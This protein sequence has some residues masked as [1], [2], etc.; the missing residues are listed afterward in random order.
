MQKPSYKDLEKQNKTLKDNI[1]GL[2]ESKN[3]FY[4]LIDN[5]P[6]MFKIIELIYDE[7]G[8][9]I[10]YYFREINTKFML[11]TNLSKGQLINKR[12]REVIGEIPEEWLIC[13]SKIL[14]TNISVS[15]IILNSPENIKYE[16]S[17]WK[18]DSNKLAVVFSDIT[19]QKNQQLEIL[20]DK[21]KAEEENR[22]K[23]EFISN[24]SHE[25]RT[26]MNGIIGFSGFL[27][28][29]E[30]TVEKRM[31]YIRII[32]NS[33][34]QLLRIVD[35][36]IEISRLETKQVVAVEDSFCFN[37]M[38]FD[39]FTVFDLRAKENKTP[40]YL[41]RGL[42]DE[43][44]TLHSDRSKLIKIISNLIDNALK[45]TNDG[46]IEFGYFIHEG[47]L[48]IYVED[49]GVGIAIQ[50]QENI[51]DRFSKENNELSNNASGLG[52]GLSIAKKNTELLKGE[53]SVKSKKGKGTTF[54]VDI[55]Y[56]PLKIS[57]SKKLIKSLDIKNMAIHTILIADDEE[58]NYIYLEILL[59]E[60]FQVN[61]KI[62][63]A[64][65]GKEAITHCAENSEINIVFMDLKM[66]LI[67]GYQVMKVIKKIRPKLTIVAQTASSS[68][69]YIKKY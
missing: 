54:F 58:I 19:D 24:L 53:I 3:E 47:N 66:P 2:N 52:L 38:L 56:K 11:F 26:P 15:G 43:A 50:R 64:K 60:K 44:S 13:Y 17:A 10:D 20:K 31:H 28:N 36:L 18:I 42:C 8:K 67:D 22:L 57:K 41:K 40:L 48:R 9:A 37:E 62:I 6:K 49:T 34:Q 69:E 27:N 14:K 7:S 63:H 21:N 29:P 59:K 23:S 16:I 12:Y 46:Y 65:N 32:Q 35:D 30:L 33:G 1:K 5:N 61:C 45:F 25:I 51:F 55:P 39:L 4:A 68:E